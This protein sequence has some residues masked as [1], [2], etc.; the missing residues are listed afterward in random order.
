MKG[1]HVDLWAVIF[2]YRYYAIFETLTTKCK[3]ILN[4][5]KITD[6][7]IAQKE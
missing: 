2:K 3:E 6:C 4:Y 7:F 1:V 5:L